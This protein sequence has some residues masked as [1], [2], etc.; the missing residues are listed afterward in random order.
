MD[1]PSVRR[2]NILEE[3]FNR[4][5]ISRNTKQSDAEDRDFIYDFKRFSKYLKEYSLMTFDVM[6]M[7]IL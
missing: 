1:V 2:I 4:S 3:G 5:F 6:R 7:I